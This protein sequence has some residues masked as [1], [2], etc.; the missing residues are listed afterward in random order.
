[1]VKVLDLY[2]PSARPT[3]KGSLAAACEAPEPR[4]S[5]VE[6]AR[7]RLDFVKTNQLKQLLLD[8]SPEQTPRRAANQTGA[9]LN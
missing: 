3:W 9:I 5:L 8:S 6:V 1:M 7:T 2:W 4:P